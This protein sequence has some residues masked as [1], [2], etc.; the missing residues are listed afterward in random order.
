MV[1]LISKLIR[2]CVS[3]CLALASKDNQSMRHLSTLPFLTFTSA[4]GLV[5]PFRY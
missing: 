2:V 1:S 4:F 3:S 5:C